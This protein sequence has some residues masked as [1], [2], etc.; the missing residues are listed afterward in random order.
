MYKVEN[1]TIYPTIE[2]VRKRTGED[3]VINVGNEIKAKAEISQRTEYIKE[4]L[5]RR[6]TPDDFNVLEGLILEEETY[7]NEFIR[8]VCRYIYDDYNMDKPREE[9]VDEILKG[10]QLLRL[11]G[12]RR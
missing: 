8:V 1:R 12:I 6:N 3:M 7:R 2:E 11:K 5:V 10:S 4:E 9:I